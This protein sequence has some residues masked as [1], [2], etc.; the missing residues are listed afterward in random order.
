MMESENE[1]T[2][3][4][5]EEFDEISDDC[6]EP[7][8]DEDQHKDEGLVENRASSGINSQFMMN[9]PFDEEQGLYF[10]G[11]SA[12]KFLSEISTFQAPKDDTT[13]PQTMEA[14]RKIVKRLVLAITNIANVREDLKSKRLAKRWGEGVRY[15][16][17]WMFEMVAWRLLYK[18]LKIHTEGWSHPVCRD[19]RII[20]KTETFTFEKRMGLVIELLTCSKTACTDVLAGED[21]TV[22]GAPDALL[23]RTN[24]NKASIDSKAKYLQDKR[25]E[26]K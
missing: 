11:A 17:P 14:K 18:I 8:L 6:T 12:M 4:D 25:E 23:E 16:E 22:V 1:A 15:Y 21:W 20:K 24:R 9:P 26:D 13:I 2:E 3:Y 5:D 19:W 10:N 7:G